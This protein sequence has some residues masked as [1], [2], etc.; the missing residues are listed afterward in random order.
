MPKRLS[1]DATHNF[2]QRRDEQNKVKT[3]IIVDFVKAYFSIML[4]HSS[5]GRYVDLYAGRGYYDR[6]EVTGDQGPIDA[7]PLAVL[8]ALVANPKFASSVYTWFNEGDVRFSSELDD[9]ILAIPGY[10]SL[11]HKPEVTT[12]NVADAALASGFD[13]DNEGLPTFAF[14]DPYGYKGLTRE[15]VSA[16]LKKWGCDVA[17]FFNYNRINMGLSHELFDEHFEKLFGDERLKRLHVELGPLQRAADRE[18]LIVKELRAALQEI[19]AKHVLMY[20]FR[21]I[22][23]RTSHHL[24][25]AS[26]DPRG[27]K[28]MREKMIQHSEKDTDGIPYFEFIAGDSSAPSLFR[29]LPPRNWPFSLESLARDLR[30]ACAGMR[31]TFKELYESWLMREELPYKETHYRK[32][33][34]QLYGRKVVM[35]DPLPPR[36]GS[37]PDDT[38]LVFAEAEQC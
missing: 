34:W 8:R 6:C 25:F 37:V 30:S 38:V 26:K 13:E 12:Y 1:S 15:L 33:L 23:G 27:Y 9:A 31:I 10:A 35:F 5:K 4:R 11:D 19:G 20:R 18:D 21:D 3:D 16:L 28:A 36:K 14:I 32:A 24:V 29:Q 7:T 17:F 2:F 22:N